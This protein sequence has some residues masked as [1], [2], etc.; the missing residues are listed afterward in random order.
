MDP[1]ANFAGTQDSFGRIGRIVT[2]GN[3]D[4]SPIA[5]AVVM[6]AAGS[7]TIIPSGNANSVALAFTDVPA[8]WS[9]PFRVRRVTAATAPVY[10][11]ED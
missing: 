3:T 5:K 9:P 2:P 8:G 4:L 10:T 6:G 11:V 1:Y 7:I